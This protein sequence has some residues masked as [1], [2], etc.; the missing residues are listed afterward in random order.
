MNIVTRTWDWT[1][2]NIKKR[3]GTFAILYSKS[4]H[5][6]DKK[7]HKITRNARKHLIVP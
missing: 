6:N 1:M 4:E 3:Q 2:W 5:K 7:C